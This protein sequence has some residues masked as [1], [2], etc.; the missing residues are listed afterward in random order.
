MAL[1]DALYTPSDRWTNFH[2]ST[3]GVS[4]GPS[5][6]FRVTTKKAPC[7]EWNTSYI[8]ELKAAPVIQKGDVIIM[9]AQ[10]ETYEVAHSYI[11]EKVNKK[12]IRAYRSNQYGNRTTQEPTVFKDTVYSIIDRS[13]F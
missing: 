2:N 4:T 11:V 1:N 5:H 7:F 10:M 8:Q 9:T 3:N 12:S 13:Q 6:P